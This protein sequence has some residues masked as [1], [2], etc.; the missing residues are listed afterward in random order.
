MDSTPSVVSYLSQ[1]TREAWPTTTGWLVSVAR[2]FCLSFISDPKSFIGTP[3]VNARLFYCAEEGSPTKLKN[4]IKL[5]YESAHETWNELRSNDW[6]LVENY[7][8]ACV[9]AG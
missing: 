4:T 2:D 1:P 6:E 9:D 5:D 8:N 7:F 3:A